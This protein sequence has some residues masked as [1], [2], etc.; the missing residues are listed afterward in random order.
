M[1]LLGEYSD[2]EILSLAFS[3][4]AKLSFG[5]RSEDADWEPQGRFCDAGLM[6]VFIWIVANSYTQAVEIHQDGHLNTQDGHNHIL[7]GK[8][9]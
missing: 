3:L 7:H 6:L 8:H 5:V 9:R 2:P 1:L 4:R